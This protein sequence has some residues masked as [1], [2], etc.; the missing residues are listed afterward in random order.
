M[1]SETDSCFVLGDGR[2]DPDGRDRKAEELLLTAAT[3]GGPSALL[4]TLARVSASRDATPVD[5]IP[6]R[7]LASMLHVFP[8]GRM[9]RG[10]I[11]HAA[12]AALGRP[13]RML[14]ALGLAEPGELD[15][16]SGETGFPCG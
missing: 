5:P 3:S 7:A 14:A 16:Q 12:R 10:R 9:A 4:V 11:A 13:G 8:P 15:L 6:E 1:L 2:R